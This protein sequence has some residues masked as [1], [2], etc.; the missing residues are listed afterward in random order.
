MFATTQLLA[1]YNI[2]LINVWAVG[3]PSI[4]GTMY[5]FLFPRFAKQIIIKRNG[6]WLIIHIFYYYSLLLENNGVGN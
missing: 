6:N 4:G 1:C 2:L 3:Y 5:I